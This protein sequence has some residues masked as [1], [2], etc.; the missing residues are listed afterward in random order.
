MGVRCANDIGNILG[1]MDYQNPNY[2]DVFRK[3]ATMLER[4]RRDPHN[5]LPGIKGYYKHNPIQFV[6]D[7][8][9]TTDPRNIERGLPALVPFIPFPKQIEWMQWLL[10]LW[11]SGQGGITEKTRDMGCSVAAMSLFSTLCLFERDF[12]A[13]VGS[14]K[15]MLVDAAG[16][17]STL[18]FKARTFLRYLPEEFRGGWRE[19]DR[20]RNSHMKIQIPE[21]ESVIIGEAGDDIGRGGRT[22]IYLVDESAHLR[23]QASVDMSLS[24][25]T[26]CRVDLSS[27]NGMANAFAEKRHSGRIPVFTFHWRDDP[28]KNQAWYEAECARLPPV[29]VAQEIDINYNASQENIL[30]PSDWVQAAIGAAE[31][32]GYDSAERVTG[33]DVADEGADSNALAC[34][35]GILLNDMHE[36]RGVGSDLFATSDKAIHLTDMYGSYH[37]RYDADGMGVGVR[38][39]ARIIN[40]ERKTPVEVVE[41]RGSGAVVNKE[42]Y[43]IDPDHAHGH[44]GRT[45]DDFFSNYKAQAWWS[46]RMRFEKTWRWVALGQKCDPS[47]CIAL[48]KDLPM[49]NKLTQ[50]LSQP[51]YSAEK[52]KI[53][54]N[55]KPDGTKSPNLADAVVIAYA[56]VQEENQVVGLL[57]RR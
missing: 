15:E 45:N 39:D 19:T 8:G 4:L 35:T 7:W 53:R 13:G 51:T 37:M 3:R 50:E 44:N 14:R 23:N 33:L 5:L 24:Q 6:I 57:L 41:H 2:T 25:T 12:V 42:A 31:I 54:V 16:N 27:V 18:F 20:Q 48:A 34:R 38:G 29:I 26:R 47:Q 32:I 49:L 52:G 36:W 40:A 1:V 43:V 17:P 10:D 56:P 30:I 11:K 55:K 46:L 22:S 21:T 9:T 28:R